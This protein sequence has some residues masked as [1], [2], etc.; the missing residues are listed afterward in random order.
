M[1]FLLVPIVDLLCV[2]D[3]S[4]INSSSV[5][6]FRISEFSPDMHDIS[7]LS[8]YREHPEVSISVFILLGSEVH[9]LLVWVGVVEFR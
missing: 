8:Y 7:Y 5:Y 9:F 2:R 1:K 3:V 6:K 4:M